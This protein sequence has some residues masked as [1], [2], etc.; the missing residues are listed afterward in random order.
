VVL[1]NADKFAA[2]EPLA[3]ESLAIREKIE[4][5]S[6]PTFNSRSM[7]GGCLLGQKK[8]DEAEPLLLAGG[9]G[10]MLRKNSIPRSARMRVNEALQRLIQL[11]EKTGRADRA[12][13]WK[14]KLAEIELVEPLRIRADSLARR[15]QFAKAAGD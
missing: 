14:Q 11:Y 3:R 5:N 1:L 13:E 8:Y 9:E 10:L 15:G 4:P 2:A 7:L 12:A 6:W